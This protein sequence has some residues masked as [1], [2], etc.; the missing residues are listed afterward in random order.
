MK[1]ETFGLNLRF[2]TGLFCT[3]WNNFWFR[4]LLLLL[5][6]LLLS[7]LLLVISLYCNSLFYKCTG[8]SWCHEYVTQMCYLL[9][10]NLHNFFVNL[11]KLLCFMYYYI[12][13]YYVSY[14]IIFYI[15]HDQIYHQ[16]KYHWRTNQKRLWLSMLSFHGQQSSVYIHRRTHSVN[17]SHSKEQTSLN[18]SSPPRFD[19]IILFQK[20]LFYLSIS[21]LMFYGLR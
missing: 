5:L 10:K 3:S 18:P 8:I 12:L 16:I 13:H 14:I 9:L 20:H 19:F 17:A 2:T 6:L 7:L 4:K 11:F 21:N 15:K 1:T